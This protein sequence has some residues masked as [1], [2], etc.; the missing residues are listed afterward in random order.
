[1]ITLHDVEQGTKEW[2][3]L[4]EGLYTGRNADKL[5]KY[6]TIE[7]A[8]THINGFGGN[9]WTKR[10]HLLED[11]AI[12]IYRRIRKM[13]IKKVGFVTNDKYPDCG[14]S[15]DG[16]PGDALPEVKSFDE[17]HH[18]QLMKAKTTEDIPFKILAQVYFGLFITELPVAHLMPYNPKMKKVA[19]RFKII[20]IRPKRSITANFRRILT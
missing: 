14:Y 4:C 15:P 10:G 11:Q 1:M 19:D 13:E 9:F 12:E 5:L 18:M 6:G 16:W 8:I 7:Y 2:H 17:E 3:D 20:E